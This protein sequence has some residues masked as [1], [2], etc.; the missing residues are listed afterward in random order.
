MSTQKYIVGAEAK[1]LLGQVTEKRIPV[2]ITAKDEANWQV[3]KSNFLAVQANRVIF[4]QPVPDTFGA[5]SNLSDGQEVAIS[6]KKGYYKHLLVSR[7]IAH[8]DYELDPGIS[9]PTIVVLIPDKIE[10]IQRRAYNRGVVPEGQTVTAAFKR[11]GESPG[12]NQS[13]QGEL[14]DLSA[15][16]LGM[17]IPESDATDLVEGEQF[18]M[19]FVPSPDQDLIVVNVR[20]RH[21][22]RDPDTSLG[23][24]GFQIIGM[25][26]SEEGRATLRRIGRV[27]G[28]YQRQEKQAKK[29][30]LVT[31]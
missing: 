29:E 8:E 14:T 22:T 12:S 9:T 1:D 19:R 17:Q 26:I 10:R 25:E 13:Y 15:G 21:I 23:T 11:I 20:L 30:D 31:Q 7:V 24:L 3:Y 5:E 27:V 6:F 2:T 16:G 28:L 18:T 4:T